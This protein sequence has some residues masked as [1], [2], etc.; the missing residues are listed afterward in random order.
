MFLA[1][2]II[3]KIVP[4]AEI[5]EAENGLQAVAFCTTRFPDIIFMDV[6]MPEMNGYEATIAIRKLTGAPHFPIIALTAGNVKGERDK[7]IAA[8]MDDFIA[9]PF[10]EETLW[11]IFNK[12][13]GLGDL[14]NS[15]NHT[16]KHSG[17]D[18]LHFDLDKL[19]DMYMNDQEFIAE[20]LILIRQALNSNLADLKEFHLKKDLQGIKAA[21]HKLKGAASSA[22]LSEVTNISAVLEHLDHF[23]YL[24]IEQ[25][26]IGL[27][28]EIDLLLPFLAEAE[29]G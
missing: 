18:K 17:P 20:F 19:R 11:Q 13:P 29:I 8:G 5:L 21:G 25:L 24:E 28:S 7:C 10:V 1:K 23:D 27:E 15:E 16:T 14:H 2:T 4:N 12:Y 9:K 26:L 6:Q 22:F 3:K